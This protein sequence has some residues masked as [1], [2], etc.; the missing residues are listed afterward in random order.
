MEVG[1]GIMLE[2]ILLSYSKLILLMTGV[3][4]S[5]NKPMILSL[6]FSSSEMK[7]NLP[8]PFSAHPLINDSEAPFPIPMQ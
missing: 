7:M 6:G 4:D 1:L 5:S 3:N 2:T 8:L